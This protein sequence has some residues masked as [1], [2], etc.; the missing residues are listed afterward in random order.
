MSEL[1]TFMNFRENPFSRFSAEEEKE[2]LKD[3]FVKP[4]YYPTIYNDIKSGG[5]RFVFGERGIGKSALV[6]N[7]MDDFQREKVFCVL[8]DDFD[9]ISAKDNTK[10]LLV[11][12]MQKVITSFGLFLLK[13]KQCLAGISK[14]EKEKLT[15]FINTFFETLSKTQ[16]YDLYDK[17]THIRSINISKRIFNWFLLKPINT[18]LSGCSEFIG[19]TISRALG[20]TAPISHSTYK[21]YIAELP[22]TMHMNK[23]DS[24][25][26]SDRSLKTMLFELTSIIKNCGFN[27]VVLIYDKIDEYRLLG[28]N[29]SSISGFI[30]D[31]VL[32]TALLL[33]GNISLVFSFWSRIRQPL[34]DV[35]VRYDKLKPIDITWSNEELNDIINNRLSYFSD[36]K[37][38]ELKSIIPEKHIDTIIEL[39]KQSPRHL[40]ML[41]SKIYDEQITIDAKST[42]FCNDAVEKGLA[43]F[44]QN[45]DFGTFYGGNNPETVKKTV[46]T[47]LKI[48]KVEFESQDIVAAYKISTQ[49]AN[50]K[51]R[52]M[53]DYGLIDDITEGTKTKQYRISEP[54]I[55]F[56]IEYNY[57][58]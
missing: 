24:M 14:I 20:L 4:R 18:V 7:L 5:S 3:I 21:E 11:F 53:L 42:M 12:S 19:S 31:F 46:K 47:L 32:D 8:I 36:K 37:V 57:K 16:F 29:V 34:A 58:L 49:A 23:I 56:L 30:K 6:L 28:T 54:R 26:L 52:T 39:T 51:I 35:G 45:F 38:I 17:T 15:L 40:I 27:G 33:N 25:T 50:G 43:N 13:N 41:L 22:E 44:A 10:E 1:Y 48:Q 9:G 2:Y 55:R